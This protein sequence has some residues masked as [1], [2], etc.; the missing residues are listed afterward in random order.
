[1]PGEEAGAQKVLGAAAMTYVA[2][3]AMAVLQFLRIL[4]I[5]RSND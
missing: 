4:M 3:L 1:M 5:F 2:A